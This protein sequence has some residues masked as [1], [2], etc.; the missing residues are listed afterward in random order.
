M[1]IPDTPPTLLP[2]RSANHWFRIG[3]RYLCL[4][5]GSPLLMTM[6][7]LVQSPL[8]EVVIAVCLV[9]SLTFC[10]ALLRVAFAVSA[11]A[12]RERKAG[13]TTL[14]GRYYAYWQL[15]HKTGEVLRR[16]GERMVIER[17]PK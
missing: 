1:T 15:D 16:P 6:S 11:A 13:Y 8:R 2:G 9:L 10:A 7:A 4:A 17:S 3:F 12:V 14:Y 5:V